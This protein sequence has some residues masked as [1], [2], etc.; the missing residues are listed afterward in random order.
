MI[1]RPRFSALIP[2]AAFLGL[3]SGP[4]VADGQRE[5]RVPAFVTAASCVV[6]RGDSVIG[7]RRGPVQVFSCPATDENVSCDFEGAEPIDL[8][9]AGVCHDAGLPIARATTV[10]VG[11]LDAQ[12]LKIEWLSFA[13][14]SRLAIVATRRVT[15]DNS[16]R[17]QVADLDQRFLR[18]S[19]PGDSPVTVPAR[20]LVRASG[21]WTLPTRMA[22]GELIARVEGAPIV[23]IRYELR[24][25][26]Q[27]DLEALDGLVALRGLPAGQYQLTAVYAG[28]IRASAARVTIVDGRSTG[29]FILKEAVGGIHASADDQVCRLATSLSLSAI[30]KVARDGQTTTGRSERIGVDLRGGCTQIAEGLRPGLYEVAYMAGGRVLSS[31]QV[32]V[33]SQLTSAV[34]LSL[35][36]V[37]VYGQVLLNGRPADAVSL[38]F[39]GESPEADDTGVTA[40]TDGGGFYE[41]FLPAAGSYLVS[42]QQRGTTLLAGDRVKDFVSGDNAVDWTLD[43]AAFSLVVEGWD[44][45]E[46]LTVSVNRV[47]LGEAGLVGTTLKIEPGEA[48]PVVV[49]GVAP[50]RYRVE[51]RERYDSATSMVDKVGSVLV[52]VE[53]GPSRRVVVVRLASSERSLTLLDQSGNPVVGASVLVGDGDRLA[54]P[55]PG[56]YSLSNVTPGTHL[57][58][59]ARGFA[60][61]CRLAPDAASDLAVRLEEGTP[62]VIEFVSPRTFKRPPGQ[63]TWP[64]APCPIPV[65]RLDH[66]AVAS[67]SG[68]SSLFRFVSFPRADD[69]RLIV[70]PYDR[71]AQWVPIRIG[72]GGTARVDLTGR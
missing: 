62:A 57:T 33:A 40:E 30:S 14:G 3:A 12:E 8:P 1:A 58:I 15:P 71:P 47:S 49:P 51:V 43:A 18:F 70:T 64:S 16:I 63:L 24:G 65:Y 48:M 13:P 66:V 46:P 23:P 6:T 67:T 2:A 17:L 28:D 59:F 21:R 38:S 69:L 19:R 25:P 60:P 5:Y 26:K 61:A 56:R 45:A 39:R 42:F 35:D 53:K 50:S 72:A 36:P 10:S 31:R 4:D 37:R 22:G 11:S 29:F 44:R 32:P 68:T 41:A 55:E 7:A 54:E 9:L 20:V 27:V 52:D 34:R